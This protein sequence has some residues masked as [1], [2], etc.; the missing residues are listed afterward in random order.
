MSDR[1]AK[2]KYSA[3]WQMTIA[4]LREFSREPA[5]IFWVYVFPILMMIVWALPFV[6][7]RLSS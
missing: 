4:R 6:I 5:A 1:F 2:L 3:F 7:D